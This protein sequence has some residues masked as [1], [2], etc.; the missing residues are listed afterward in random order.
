MNIKNL[1]LRSLL[2]D[3]AR[4]EEIVRLK[5]HQNFIDEVLNEYIEQASLELDAP[6]SFI[7]IVLDGVQKFA[8]LHGVDGWIREAQGTAVEWSF[9]INSFE[10][11]LPFVVEDTE[12]N[13]ITKD[14][15]LVKVDKVKS[16][17]GA[18][19]ITKNGK[20]IGNFCVAGVES[21]SFTEEEIKVL[22]KYADL[23]V[24]RLEE[25]II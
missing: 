3:K 22:E 25:R 16:Y 7:S 5:L 10:T 4:L 15:P 9:C 17:A 2:L 6:I 14:N 23:T 20:Q 21:R 1:R 12:A 8:S 13:P 24:K 11:Q 18:P 19:M